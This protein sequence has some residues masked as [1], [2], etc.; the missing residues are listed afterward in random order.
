MRVF[1]IAE[2]GSNWRAGS[3]DSDRAMARDLIAAARD[4][5]ADAVKFQTFRSSTTYAESAGQI[6]YLGEIGYETS[7][8]ELFRDLEMPYDLIPDLARWSTEAGIEFMS[9][10]FSVD[11]A[12]AVDPW[13]LRHKVASYEIGHVRLIEWMARTGKPLL[14]S[15]G[16]A[17]GDDI[18]FGLRTA[19]E[20]GASDVTLLQCTASYPAP[21]DSLNLNVIPAMRA[22]YGTSVGLSDHSRDPLVGPVMAVALGATAIEKHFTIDRSLPGPDHSF[23][24][25]PHELASMV[26]AI[27]DAESALGSGDKTVQPTEQPLR[28]FAVRSIQAT[29]R[30]DA[31]DVL[32]EGDNFEV[33]RPGARQRGLHPRFLSQVSGRRVQRAIEA[34]EGILAEDL[35]PPL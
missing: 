32:I 8:N 26:R 1:V 27:R 10:P 18:E 11:D 9:T 34:G 29:R 6:G 12:T 13:V 2:A 15:T 35:E 28:D 19:R 30:I 5:G 7:I 4:S 24:V 17:V 23:A 31:H 22:R 33:L 25:E 3:P 16:A 21:T 20:A 14:M